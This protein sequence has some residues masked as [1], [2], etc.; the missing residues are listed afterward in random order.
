MLGRETLV[1]VGL[2][3]HGVVSVYLALHLAEMLINFSWMNESISAYLIHLLPY[4]PSP[5]TSLGKILHNYHPFI[6]S[7]NRKGASSL[8]QELF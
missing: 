6:N 1:C 3:Y 8:F 5:S 4:L 2:I 7:T